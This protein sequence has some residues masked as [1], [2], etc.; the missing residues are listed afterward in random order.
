M[1]QQVTFDGL[2]NPDDN[3]KEITD[4]FSNKSTKKENTKSIKKKSTTLKKN[5]T[6][7]KISKESKSQ[8][9]SSSKKKVLKKNEKIIFTQED[10]DKLCEVFDWY[11]GIRDS[12][13]INLNSSSNI[14]TVSESIIAKKKKI[15]LT[16]DDEIWSN[17]SVLCENIGTKKG[18]LISE[19]LKEYLVN[20]KDLI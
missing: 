19:I 16:V 4:K 11:I 18:E 6:S 7:E 13:E 3:N 12:L 10:S 17:F 5:K 1:N 9:K 14:P 15:S 8:K 20:H 2:I